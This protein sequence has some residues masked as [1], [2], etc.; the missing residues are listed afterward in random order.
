MLNKSWQRLILTHLAEKTHAGVLTG[1]P[2]T[3]MSI[4]LAAGRAHIKHTEGG[5]FR[6]ATYRALRQG[7]RSTESI[8]LEPYYAFRLEVPAAAVGRAMADVQRMNGSFEPPQL[9]GETAV[10]TGTAPVAC[11]RGYAREVAGYTQGAGPFF[12]CRAGLCPLP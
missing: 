1:A 8:L 3:D 4:T 6:Q 2:V 5:D 10:L 9:C 7:L 11:M 12:G